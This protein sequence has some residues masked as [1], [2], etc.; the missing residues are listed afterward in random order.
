[1][2]DHFTKWVEDR[3]ICSK[4]ALT[5]PNNVVHEWVLNHGA[6]MSLYTDQGRGFTA[7]LYQEVYD[8]LRIPKIYSTAYRPQ[9]NGML[10]QC[11]L[12]SWQCCEQ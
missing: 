7:A 6:P 9:C 8:L 3:V 1:M 11:N 2:Q 5:V 10:E 12:C 4:E